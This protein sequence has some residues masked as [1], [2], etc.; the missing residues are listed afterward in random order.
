MGLGK[1]FTNSIARE[2]G[3]NYGKAASNYLLGDKHSTPIRMVG[4]N[5]VGRKRGRVY[6][7]DFDKHIKKFEIK[8][9][10][11]TFSQ[12]LNIH[13]EFFTLVDEAQADGVIDL[14]ELKFLVQQIPR[15][16]STCK[17][18]AEAIAELG[19]NELSKK[20]NEKVEGF[21]EFMKSLNASLDISKLP[22]IK[23]NPIV[24]LFF[25]LSFIGLDRVYFNPKKIS[26][27]FFAGLG[28]GFPYWINYISNSDTN[29]DGFMLLYFWLSVS[30]PLWY[31][32]I[33]NPYQNGGYWGYQDVKK[34]QKANN[35]LAA[36]LKIFMEEQVE[37]Y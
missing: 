26:G 17:R 28:L 9:A 27:Y 12:I 15:A 36:E 6:E 5:Y 22:E 30:L 19:D 13:N 37:S 34:R 20:A 11:T 25:F 24:F 14:Q 3:R 10:K 23:F 8:T 31:G 29:P 2:I 33:L 18:G 7:N 35:N 21:K 4:S 32:M 16:I 1:T